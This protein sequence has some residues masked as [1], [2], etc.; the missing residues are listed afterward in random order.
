MNVAVPCYNYYSSTR[1]ASSGTQHNVRLERRDHLVLVVLVG[2]FVRRLGR[3]VCQQA[4]GWAIIAGII[5][6]TLRSMYSG[7]QT[8]NDNEP[9]ASTG[10]AN[11]RVEESVRDM[12][13]CWDFCIAGSVGARLKEL[14]RWS[15][16]MEWADRNKESVSTA[17]SEPRM[18]GMLFYKR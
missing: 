3:K 1:L 13:G 10:P 16:S 18:E 14:W 6:T 2:H 7:V 17:S 5:H 11:L 9:S 12:R 8:N 4:L 15:D